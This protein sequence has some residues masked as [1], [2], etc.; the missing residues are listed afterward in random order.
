MRYFYA[1]MKGMVKMAEIRLPRG[2]SKKIFVTL[3]INGTEYT[4]AD[5][6]T[7]LFTIK[8]RKDTGTSIKLQKQLTSE[9]YNNDGKIVVEIEP[10]DTK[11]WRTGENGK[12]YYWDFAVMLTGNKFYTP[13][14]AG[15]FMLTPALGSIGD[16]ED[17]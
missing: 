12:E 17:D 1:L 2:N 4:L 11:D 15:T 5:G 7:A 9:D 14:T 6:E 13:V 10:D 3:K 16:V 8:D